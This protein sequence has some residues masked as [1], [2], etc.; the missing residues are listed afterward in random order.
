MLDQPA[1]PFDEDAKKLRHFRQLVWSAIGA[2]GVAR[3]ND[4]QSDLEEVLRQAARNPNVTGAVLDDF[5]PSVEGFGA[6]GKRARHSIESIAAMQKKLHQFP[7]RRLDLWLVW[8]SYQL[9]YPVQDYV[10]LCDVVTLWTWNGSDLDLL[11]DHIEKLVEKT[12][13]KR[14]LAG[15][16]LW[17]YGERKELTA[18]QMESQLNSY[19]RGLREGA[20]EGIVFCSNCVAD[21]GLEA[22]EMTREW[23]RTVGPEAA[24]GKESLVAPVSAIAS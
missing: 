24:P 23:I 20:I 16:Y 12:P 14:R 11:D 19:H 4:D 1:P 10:D 8:Y 13:G 15:C 18:K 22:A 9:D 3:N 7:Q 17:N 5:F 21:C 6:D 2:G